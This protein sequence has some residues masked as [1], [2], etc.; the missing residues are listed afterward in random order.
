MKNLEESNK[1]I[2]EN[3]SICY[4]SFSKDLKEEEEKFHNKIKMENS[5][6]RNK[7]IKLYNLADK[8]LEKTSS[9]TPCKKRV[10]SL[11]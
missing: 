9:F 1:F 6:K 3:T 11:L 4:N 2:Q 7:L 5:S 10:F 8:I